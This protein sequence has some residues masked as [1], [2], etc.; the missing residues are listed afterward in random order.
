MN[1]RARIARPI[2]RWLFGVLLAELFAALAPAAC[3]A[4]LTTFGSAL[5]VSATRDTANDLNYRGSDV[6]L[7]GSVFH[8][9]HDGADT[10]L[11]N[12][13]QGDGGASAPASGQVVSV[14]L[15][16]CAKQPSGAPAPLTQ[17]HFQDLGPAPGGGTTVRVTTQAFDIPVCGQA[18]ASGSTVTTYVPTNFCV[19][20]GDRVGFND[21][22][23]FV[24]SNSGPPPYPSGV[25]YM[26]IGAVPG[27][28]MDSFI[29]NHGV[30]NGATFSPSD[31]SYHD[32]F[33]SNQGEELMLQATLATGPDATPLCPGGTHGVR[34]YGPSAAPATPIRI[35]PQTDGVNHSAIVSVAMYCRL[36]SDCRG[37][38]S[39][40]AAG[41]QASRA[42]YGHTSFRLPGKKTSHV[43]IRVS[44]RMMQLLRKHRGGV[45]VTVTASVGGKRVTQTITLRIF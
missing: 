43:P 4:A 10:A 41:T 44:S 30:G 2:R 23:G 40:A 36:S 21:E 11:W 14:R 34:G 17:I 25:P 13:Q 26:V 6:A 38:A 16:G 15:E 3:P 35:I 42:S 8:I 22:G 5:S 37:V 31:T 7:P 18:G 20:Q 9:P 39:L 12:A 32:G 45:P 28:T 27:S 19:A 33:A 1:V 24:P 29:R